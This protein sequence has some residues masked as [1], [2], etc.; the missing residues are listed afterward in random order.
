MASLDM[1]DV[2]NSP[3][4]ADAVRPYLTETQTFVRESLEKLQACLAQ[5]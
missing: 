2:L 5:N 4:P 3:W 1:K